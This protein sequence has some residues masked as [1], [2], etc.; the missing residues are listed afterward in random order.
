MQKKYISTVNKLKPTT[1]QENAPVS[2]QV[3]ERASLWDK[4]PF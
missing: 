2:Q 4:G 1:L 3:Q